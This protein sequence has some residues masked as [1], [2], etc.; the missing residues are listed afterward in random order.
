M[1]SW[2]K[3]DKESIFAFKENVA[4]GEVNNP[5]NSTAEQE[6]AEEVGRAS[7]MFESP[8]IAAWLRE[9]K[10]L[11]TLAPAYQPCI[12]TTKMTANEAAALYCDYKVMHL[13]AI[14][15]MKPSDFEQ[16]AMVALKALEVE[17]ASICSDVRDGWK[18][19]LFVEH[20][21]RVEV[22]LK[23]KKS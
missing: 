10:V 3:K 5:N 11:N 21:R 6:Y 14:I 12:R 22:N 23:D 18:G 4:V 15:N 8:A 17:A 9:S 16:G 1:F 7:V 19:H 2:L 20:H 13:L